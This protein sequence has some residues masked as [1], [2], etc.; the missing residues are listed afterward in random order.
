M[1]NQEKLNAEIERVAKMRTAWV[2]VFAERTKKRN[3]K[4]IK[5]KKTKKK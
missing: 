3:Y 1:T 2:E 5:P 4:N